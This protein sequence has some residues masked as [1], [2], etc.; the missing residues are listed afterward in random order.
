MIG[1]GIA[2]AL[3]L[4]ALGS[5]TA[6]HAARDECLAPADLDAIFAYALPT[7]IDA[8]GQACRPSLAPDGFLATQGVALAARYRAGQAA[9]WPVAKAA[10]LKVGVGALTGHAGNGGLG[11]F[12]AMLPDSALQGFA[13]GFV[14]A[15]VVQAVHPGD[16]PDIE[17]A[18]RLI[19]PLPPENAAGLI[20]LVVRR[21]DRRTI[22][23]KQ[24]GHKLALP[25]CPPQPVTS[26]PPLPT[27]H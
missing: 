20:T 19:A 15:Y 13:S 21:L 11:K 4:L 5:V 14:A 18:L 2:T 10:V 7:V 3:S 12:A 8:A 27:D 9:S 16:C 22:D 1:K 6:A 24:P 25:L 23:A 17:Y 26:T